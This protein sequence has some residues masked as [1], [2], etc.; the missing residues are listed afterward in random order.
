MKYKALFWFLAWIVLAAMA[1]CSREDTSNNADAD[2][3]STAAVASA[4]TESAS[5]AADEGDSAE[6]RP[7]SIALE[8]VTPEESADDDGKPSES[9]QPT[10]SP[11][12]ARTA[13]FGEKAQLLALSP[14][15]RRAPIDTELGQLAD[16]L[17]ASGTDRD[18]LVTIRGF[19]RSVSADKEYERYLDP[20]RRDVLVRSLSQHRESGTVPESVRY[21]EVVSVEPGEA[22]VNV[23]C[24]GDPGE[25]EGEVIVRETAG[26]WYVSVLAVDLAMLDV[27]SRAPQEPFEPSIYRFDMWE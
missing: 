10:A 27:P 12:P 3:A 25:A 17:G 15:D 16:I 18:V 20:A 9:A 26:A 2:P 19:F 13:P 5:P 1:G 21:G 23:R 4:D 14:M 7:D 6:R 24:Y 8:P 22:R 11:K